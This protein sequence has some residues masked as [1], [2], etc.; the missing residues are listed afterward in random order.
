MAGKTLSRVRQLF[1]GDE[2]GS[3]GVRGDL[4]NGCSVFWESGYFALGDHLKTQKKLLSV[5]AFIRKMP[6]NA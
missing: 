1:R 6:Q 2:E 5:V 4:S 3:G